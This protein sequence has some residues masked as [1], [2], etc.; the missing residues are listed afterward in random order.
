MLKS[1]RKPISYLLKLRRIEMKTSKYL[2]IDQNLRHSKWHYVR[3]R[4]N[5]GP[6]DL[7]V[8]CTCP[9]SQNLFEII[10]CDQLTCKHEESYALGLSKDKTWLI[11][12]VVELIDGIY[13]TK[14]LTYEMLEA[15]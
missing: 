1:I 5:R 6:K 8:L 10:T 9:H 12:Y 15:K 3:I 14:T 2:K 4:K 13:N 11:D 7:Y